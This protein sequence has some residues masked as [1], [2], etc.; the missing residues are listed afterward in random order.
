[1]IKIK[2]IHLAL[3]VFFLEACGGSD[4]NSGSS[5]LSSFSCDPTTDAREAAFFGDL[6]Q[7]PEIRLTMYDG[8]KSATELSDGGNVLLVEPPQG[9]MI[10]YIGVEATNIGACGLTLH[11]SFRDEN[12]SQLRFDS[13]TINLKPK[14]D[15]WGQSTV[16]DAGTFANVP[17]CP[18]QWSQSDI[19]GTSYLLTV[20][21]NDLKGREARFEGHVTPQ[22]AEAKMELCTC[23]CKAGYVLGQICS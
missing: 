9:G 21:I 17:L 5:S 7:S 18:N 10:S 8:S 1:M 15:G 12:N 3:A 13:R 4:S 16:A 6:D 22:C 19:F 14:G 23:I 2:A 20:T 11:A